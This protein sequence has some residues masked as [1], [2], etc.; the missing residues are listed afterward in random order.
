[1]ERPRRCLD[2]MAIGS[3]SRSPLLQLAAAAA[4]AALPSAAAADAVSSA[5][6]ERLLHLEGQL[7]TSQVVFN[8]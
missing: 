3:A 2:A 8:G 5:V 7:V 1:M 4:M 6:A